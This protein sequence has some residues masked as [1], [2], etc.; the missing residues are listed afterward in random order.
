[1]SVGIEPAKCIWLGSYLS[2][3]IQKIR[4]SDAVSKD[5]KVAWD[6][7]EG[8]HPLCFIGFVN[9]I[10]EIFDYVCVLLY[11]DDM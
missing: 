6:V 7:P 9:T 1:M 2:G 10:S 11:A 5:I 3:R 8:S 4:I